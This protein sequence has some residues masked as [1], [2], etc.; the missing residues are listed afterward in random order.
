MAI[1]LKLIFVSVKMDKP[2]VP[3]TMKVTKTDLTKT[4]Q[5]VPASLKKTI[6][7]E[8]VTALITL[9]GVHAKKLKP[10]VSP[11]LRAL[12]PLRV[13]PTKIT[14]SALAS[15]R[16]TTAMEKVT[17]SI[18][19]GVSVKRHKPS[20]LPPLRP[21]K[22]LRASLMKITQSALTNPRRTTAMEKVTA[23]KT[24]SGAHAKK[25]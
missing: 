24:L 2:S 10:F 19:I 4:T 8:K 13:N 18:L 23:T 22:P 25:L 15:L 6:A 1:A 14:L 12:K 21:L 7:M 5:S 17:V 3:L 16:R 20:V 9:I 11:A